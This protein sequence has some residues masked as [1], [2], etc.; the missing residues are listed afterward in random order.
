M[1][2]VS[3]INCNLNFIGFSGDGVVCKDVDE[4]VEG[5][6]ECS[7]SDCDNTE[8]SYLC[9][10]HQGKELLVSILNSRQG[11]FGKRSSHQLNHRLSQKR[12]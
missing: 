6:D 7:N 3:A 10:C 8:G 12:C 4:C 2:L 5:T 1:R 9:N 11:S